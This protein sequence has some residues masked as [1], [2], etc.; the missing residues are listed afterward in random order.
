[1][2]ESDFI[3]RLRQLALSA[4]ARGL[5]DDCA[6]SGRMVVTHDMMVAG[7]H[8]PVDADPADV[9]WKLV[10]VNLSDLA[11]K[12]ARPCG[13]LLGYMLGDE[14]WDTRFL[15]GL[16]EALSGM[17]VALWGGDT[18][19]GAESGQRSFGLTAI[20]EAVHLPVPSRS[21]ARPGDALW[22]TGEIGAAMLGFEG[23]G[24]A[25]IARFARPVPR[26]AEGLALAPLVT[27]MMDV[28]DGLLLDAAR[29]ADASR[30]SIAIDSAVVPFPAALPADRRDAAMR[31]GD[32]YELLFTLPAG[33]SPPVAATRIGEV[34]ARGA[35]PLLVDGAVP[36]PGEALGYQH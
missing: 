33:S 17:E 25:E 20:G 19:R 15:E 22:V 18:V 16:A 11:A 3:A 10:A 32:D 31:W 35:G 7:V 36:A 5:A 1:M 6:V 30:V 9:A 13:V 23:A 8:F 2:R 4:E 21:G 27:A 24:A 26:I 34:L 28:S 29:M 12:G 14:A